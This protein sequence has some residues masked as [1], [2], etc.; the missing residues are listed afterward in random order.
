MPHRRRSLLLTVLV[1]L[2]LTAPLFA[3][4][5]Y[6]TGAEKRA[7]EQRLKAL[8][9]KFLAEPDTHQRLQIRGDMLKLDS[10][11][12]ENGFSVPFFAF[13][14]E[15]GKEKDATTGRDDLNARLQAAVALSGIDHETVPQTIAP[16]LGD[17]NDAVRLRV[18]KG[19]HDNGI[20]R[21]WK[22]VIPLL[23]D[24]NLEIRSWAAKTLGK[25]GEQGREREVTGAL[26]AL[27]VRSWYD[28][29]ATSTDNAA[30]RASLNALIE[31]TGK[32]LEKVTGTH[33]RP[34]PETNQLHK[35]IEAY[36]G[37]WNGTF[38]KMLRDPRLTERRDALN[39]IEPTADRTVVAQVIELM[40][41]EHSRWLRAPQTDKRGHLSLLISA[42]KILQR[43]SGQDVS[44]TSTSSPS[45][46]ADAIKQWTAWWTKEL[47]SMGSS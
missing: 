47:K 12:G 16:M 40:V 45:E 7:L 21:A 14:Y 13:I 1:V 28:L 17:R 29:N 34:T 39:A 5:N 9:I 24:P 4:G 8:A 42:N 46:V 19:I 31:T 22:Q 26:T 25:L 6:I 41:Q 36:T 37:P 11:K 44:L 23:E 32:A 35:T 27:L 18:L 3:Q 10:Y 15:K 20:V 2:L 33:W 30:Q 38:F 43:V